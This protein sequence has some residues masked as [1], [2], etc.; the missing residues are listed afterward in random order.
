[1]DRDTVP[2]TPSLLAFEQDVHETSLAYDHPNMRSG[3]SDLD[4]EGEEDDESEEEVK[5]AD[6][7]D[8]LYQ[9]DTAE[10]E[11]EE[12]EGEEAMDYKD[13]DDDD[14]D[15]D[16]EDEHPVGRTRYPRRQRQPV[17]RYNPLD[18]TPSI[19]S[20]KP[21]RQ[22]RNRSDSLGQTSSATNNPIPK[23]RLT[24]NSLRASQGTEPATD[25]QSP[26]HQLDSQASKVTYRSDDEDEYDEDEASIRKA[27]MR[28]KLRS[29]TRPSHG[30]TTRS[31]KKYEEEDTNRHSGDDDYEE[32][33]PEPTQQRQLRERKKINYAILAPEYDQPRKSSMKDGLGNGMGSKKSRLPWSVSGKHLDRMF[34]GAPAQ[35]D[36][37]DDDFGP[38]RNTSNTFGPTGAGG[39]M[40]GNSMPLDMGTGP[41]N[42]GKVGDAALS[43]ADPLGTNTNITF[44][45]VGGLDHHIQRLKEMVSL[46]LL[47]PELFQ[48]FNVTPPRGVLF[49]GPPGTGKTL[50]ARALAAS[51]STSGTKISFFMRKGADCLSKWVGEAE[52]QLRLLFEEAKTCQPSI[53]FFD[54]IDGLAPVRSS[55][56]DQ[57]H[58]S[59]VSTLLALMDGMDGRGQV[60]I[61]GATNRPDAVDPALRRPGRF[62]REF[63]FPLPNKEA[64]RKILDIN[65]AT[66]EPKLEDA[67]LD[68]LAGLTKGYGGADL[69]ALCTEASLNAIQRRYPQIYKSKDRLLLQPETI[70]VQAK[71]FMIS[72]K[73]LIPSSARSASSAAVILPQHLQPL[74]AKPL[75]RTI[76]AIDKALPPTKKTSVLEDAEWESDDPKDGSFESHLMMQ[77]FESSRVYRP[78]IL[79]H[80]E[81]GLGQTH[82]A[83]AVLHHLEG[84][85]VQSLDLATLMSDSTRTVEAALVQ[86]FIEAKRH[87]P[88][89]IF[90]PSLSQWARVVSDM[91]RSTVKSLLD[92]ISSS[93]PVLLLAVVDG[94]LDSLPRDVKSWFG[95]SK[96][97]RIALSLPIDSERQEFFSKVVEN[98]RIRPDEFPGGMPRKERILEELP[99][100][101][102]L[103][104]RQ[105]SAAEIAALQENDAKLIEL[106]KWKLGPVLTDLKRKF[107]SF[108]K[109]VH[110]EY[111]V[112]F[113]YLEDIE[114][115]NRA[116]L[117]ANDAIGLSPEKAALHSSHNTNDGLNPEIIAQLIDV[118]PRLVDINLEK[119]HYAL[120]YN[121]YLSPDE[122]LHDITRIADNAEIAT[123]DM[124]RTIKAKRMMNHAFLLVDQSCDPQFRLDC[125]RM[126]VREKNREEERL[127]D[128]TSGRRASMRARGN[129]ETNGGYSPKGTR[130]STRGQGKAPEFDLTDPVALERTLKRRREGSQSRGVDSSA[131]TPQRGDSSLK[132]PRPTEDEESNER[133]LSGVEPLDG[134][135]GDEIHPESHFKIHPES[136]FKIHLENHP[137]SHE[138]ESEKLS[139][140]DVERTT[141]VSVEMNGEGAIRPES[142]I[143]IPI[144]IPVPTAKSVPIP[145][146][147]H[148]PTRQLSLSDLMHPSATGRSTSLEVV[149][150]GHGDMPPSSSSSARVSRLIH[151]PT[152]SPTSSLSAT[153]TLSS[154]VGPLS[155]PAVAVSVAQPLTG[156][157]QEL[158]VLQNGHVPSLTTMPTTTA[159][160]ERVVEIEVE[161]VSLPTVPLPSSPPSLPL[162]PPSPLP[163][164]PVFIC[165][166][167]SLE[168]I[169]AQLVRD[170]VSFNVDELEQIRAILLDC[171]WRHRTEW[172]RSL[173]M[174]EMS[175]LAEEF[176]HEVDGNGGDDG[177]D[178]MG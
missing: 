7:S 178:I 92:S 146:P 163:P 56:Q 107:K 177:W 97:N 15:D 40:L 114:N 167:S 10:G 51:C 119:M 122:F 77:S 55:K 26:S 28:I 158:P 54:E 23:I 126:A 83:A 20:T 99:I 19:A 86:L 161:S 57:I 110:D 105:P 4:A 171:I 125:R 5:H 174:D 32:G 89:A 53:I 138:A 152:M 46:P 1:M 62:D 52:R 175:R 76:A 156:Y 69:R 118:P 66:W 173:M 16:D 60:I 25:N 111:R 3:G 120:Y 169:E 155:V 44:D 102:A 115:K 82:I 79:I 36:D 48:R 67:L 24:R 137:L 61:I 41:S 100:A 91:A 131:S 35:G 101:P 95:Y 73:N 33:D 136:H 139:S 21:S 149:S 43:D 39:G 133:S 108:S 124:E 147:V 75:A 144:P 18:P 117:E 78:R 160:P 143:P 74:L 116:V 49:H 106:V 94:E 70:R 31:T 104:P 14:D 112:Y 8:G 63:Y 84:F 127:K 85:H 22:L 154:T 176:K 13:V 50:V 93:D 165:S 141:D 90:I 123:D 45:A 80:G 130:H 153:G 121:R 12:D 113:D 162:P 88:S 27:P 164:P 64:R 168:S 42:M 103:P 172:D 58:A 150:Q 34:G 38:K 159:A 135:Q 6:G 81:S 134:V 140:F 132:K 17:E 109:P 72:I 37:S 11:D 166:T 151:L 47:Y 2:P 98:V 29:V 96:D 65:T 59:I 71:D 68:N 87:K 142:P 170:S 129:R 128:S 148:R 30:R 145:F 9:N 157:S